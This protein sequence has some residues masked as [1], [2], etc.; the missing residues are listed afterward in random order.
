MSHPRR[1]HRWLTASLLALFTLGSA[2]VAGPVAATSG[3]GFH[4]GPWLRLAADAVDLVPGLSSVAQALVGPTAIDRGNDNRLTVLLVGSDHR[5]SEGTGERL[6]S[7]LV[8]TINHKTK[9]I[10][11]L[12]IPRDTGW[13][14]LAEGGTFKAKINGLF[15]Y[16]KKQSGGDRD[17]AMAKFE[18][19]IEHV[20][21]IQIDYH[22]LIRFDGFD[23]LV[24]EVGGVPTAIPSEIRD[25]GYIDKPGWPK[26]ARFL[27]NDGALLRG[28]D[29]AR[30]Y[31][32]YPRGEW[33][34][35]PNCLRA[36]VYVRS[37]KGKVGNS[38][39]SDWK[40]SR[41]QQDFISFAIDRVTGRNLEQAY[42]LRNAAN[43]L[44][45][46]FY[47]NMPTSNADVM[48]VYDLLKGSN[49][50]QQVVLSPSTYATRV[51]GTS[52]YKLKLP[53]VRQ[54]TGSWFGPI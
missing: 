42:A 9:N 41:R 21:K 32:P 30:C 39:N 40:R 49:L 26:G 17:T 46:D 2:G 38:A 31:G 50:T 54:L 53:E 6:D 25:T 11:A 3:T 28:A 24:D 34:T 52:K 18:R 15:K 4:P 14:P 43:G 29:A 10:A 48:A 23:A 33:Q 51:S 20:L 36:L 12:S 13:I 44:S 8:M 27:V 35:A 16:Y 37:R 1:P 5:D 45:N 22:A 47:T 19:T 7:I